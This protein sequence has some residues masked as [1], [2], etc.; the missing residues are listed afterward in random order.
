MSTEFKDLIAARDAAIEADDDCIAT[1]D[2][3]QA[4]LVAAQEACIDSGNKR[5][6]AHKAIQAL[7]VEYGEHY[8]ISEDGTLTVYKPIDDEP[9]YLAV[10]PI[11]GSKVPTSKHAER[12]AK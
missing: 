10:Q 9:G 8:L 3:A 5:A 1:R 6:E 2:S 11:P 4:A 7:L 12:K